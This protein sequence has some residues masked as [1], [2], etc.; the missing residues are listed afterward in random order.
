MN[1]K[2][3]GFTL[4]EL[5]VVISVIAILLGILMPALSTAREIGKRAVC[6]SNM[7]G[8]QLSWEL[9][10]NAN[11]DKIVNGE[12]YI[13][14]GAEGTNGTRG[15]EAYWCG[16][17]NLDWIGR[18]HA[19]MD[20]QYAA[21]QAGALWPYVKNLKIYHCPTG[22]RGEWR[23]YA[24]VDSM[25]GMSRTGT[26]TGSG[27]SKRG[28]KEGNTVLWIKRKAEII[29]PSAGSRLVFGDEG[30]CT[31][32]SIATNYR[33]ETWWDPGQVRHSKGNTYSF[34]DGHCDYWKW[35]GTGTI[36]NGKL[37]SPAQGFRPVSDEDYKDLYKFQIGV[38]G[39]LGY[40]PTHSL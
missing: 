5:L 14:N 23:N 6:L 26:T 3:R 8:L 25:N 13:S 31:D 16:D 9:Y 20:L 24:I 17:D 21:I 15:G 12:S 18:T 37:A 36:A 29:Q 7:K 39:R 30:M 27:S 2:H 1:K 10:A 35:K 11:D 38:W 34:A 19:A 32:D 22:V 28:V 40:T 4:I 33:T